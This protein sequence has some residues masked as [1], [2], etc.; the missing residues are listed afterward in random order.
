MKISQSWSYWPELGAAVFSARKI[1]PISSVMKT[2]GLKLKLTLMALLLVMTGLIFS[3]ILTYRKTSVVVDRLTQNVLQAQLNGVGL[4]LEMSRSQEIDRLKTLILSSSEKLMPRLRIDGFREDSLEIENQET[5]VKLLTKV[6]QL[7]VD[8]KP[9]MNQETVDRIGSETAT[10]VTF[11]VVSPEGLLRVS[12]TVK[13]NN[14][15]RAVYTYI[16]KSSNVTKSILAGNSYFGRA[17]VLGKW[18]S[19]AYIPIMQAGRPVGA[20]FM[21]IPE[22]STETVSNYLKSQKLLKTGYFYILDSKGTFI[23]HPSLQGK[24]VIEKTDLDGRSIFKE[25]LAAKSGSIEYRWL[26]AE[27]NSSQ[28]KLAIFKD[29]PEVDWIVAASLNLAEAKADVY[30]LRLLMWYVGLAVMLV[31]ITV[32]WFF[33]SILARD[34][35]N[36]SA[37]LKN[38]LDHIYEKSTEIF[39]ASNSL[40]NFSSSQATGVQETAATLEEVRATIASNMQMI[41]RSEELSTLTERSTQEGSQLMMELTK[42]IED[43]SVGNKNTF[44]QTK[45]SYEKI[46]HISEVLK[47]IEGRTSAINDIVFQTKLLSFNASV[48]AARAGENGKGFAVV[49]E[50]IGKLASMTGV[51]ASEINK[52]MNKSIEDVNR[53]IKTSEENVLNSFK[54]AADSITSSVEIS[55]KTTNALNEILERTRLTDENMKQISVAS[56][57]QAQAVEQIAIAVN[58]IEKGIQGTADSAQN[59]NDISEALNEEVQELVAIN[60]KIQLIVI[61]GSASPVKDAQAELTDPELKVAAKAA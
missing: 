6:P 39:N 38:A 49:A 53:L 2:L 23:M 25:I 47:Q 12:T 1:M 7:F 33:T 36:V 31:M 54:V 50:E 55:L 58:L 17:Q 13:K 52:M 51:T 19:A 45:E 11:F 20:Y 29:F 28:D 35:I 41:I 14:G 30:D 3:E 44:T 46:R 61:G 42:A 60:D 4:A 24:N 26:N 15:D 43:V 32:T 9:L 56:R 57:E 22:T 10:A 5:H 8:G 18:F 37:R 27:T 59:A 48:E 34:F 16:P 21:G 40:A